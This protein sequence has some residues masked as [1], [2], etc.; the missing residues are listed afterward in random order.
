MN[1]TQKIILLAALSLTS[2]AAWSRDWNEPIFEGEVVG[3][4]EAV[5]ACAHEGVKLAN[6]DFTYELSELDEN[7][8]QLQGGIAGFYRYRIKMSPLG[9]NL[10]I[11]ALDMSDTPSEFL[12]NALTIVTD[13]SEGMLKSNWLL[14]TK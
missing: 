13:C 14:D 5:S 4:L 2:N 6:P 10:V 12:E 11:T 9:E 8:K 1:I 3:T 7:T